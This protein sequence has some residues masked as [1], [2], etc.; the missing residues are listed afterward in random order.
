MK[1]AIVHIADI[2]YRK[3]EPEGVSRVLD[4]FMQDLETQK[5]F[6]S[7][8]SFYIAFTGDMVFAGQ[9][10]D[11][12]QTLKNELNLK[13]DKI[14][15]SYES[16]I[17]VPGNH[18]VE[19]NIVQSNLQ[20]TQEQLSK[21]LMNEQ[22]FNSFVFSENDLAEKFTNYQIFE[23]EFARYGIDFSI[24]GKGWELNDS[25]GIYCLNSALTSF[26]GVNDI[27]D[28]KKLAICTRDLTNWCAR[29]KTSTN[30]LLMH[31]PID[32]LIDWSKE[33]I[34]LLIE[35]N[36]ILCL[37][38]HNHEQNIFYNQISQKALI[39][40]APQLF[41]CKGDKLGYAIILLEND[42]PD[43]ILYRQYVKGNFLNGSYFSQNNEGIVVIPTSYEKVKPVKNQEILEQR[44]KNS[45]VS[46]KNQPDLFIEPKLSKS[47]E[48]NN[49][50]NQLALVIQNPKAAFIIAQPQFGLTCLAHYMRLEAYKK[51]KFWIYV[52]AEHV[53][54][55]NV[56]K[57]IEEQLK[58]F[59]KNFNEIQC[60]LIDSW[61]DSNQDNQKLLKFVDSEYSEIPIIVMSSYLGINYSSNLDF[62]SLKT[63]FEFLHLQAL[64]RDKV[65]K[66]V[67]E[68]NK[69]KRIASD[70]E[71]I[72]KVVK[73]LEALN[74]HRTPLNCYTL[75]RVFERD[76]NES[77]LNRT[78]MIKIVLF[79]LFTDV[80]SIS[81]GSTKPD[82]DDVE[83][84][85]GKFCKNL[86]KQRTTRFD[87]TEFKTELKRFS[88][89]ALFSINVEQIIDILE[90]NYI[91]KRFGDDF[92]FRHSYWI[93]YFAAICMT[94]DDEFRDYIL[95]SRNYVNFPEIIEFY[96]GTNG[97]RES[98]VVTLIKDTNDLVKAVSN[99]IG[100]REEFN[101]F[102]DVLWNPTKEDI[103]LIRREISEI[104]QTSNLPTD[105]KDQ[106]ADEAYDSEAPYNQSINKFLNEYMVVSLIQNIK[107]SSRALRNSNYVKP[108]FKKELFQSILN[109]WEQI[110]RVIFWLAPALA[111]SGKVSYDGYGLLLSEKFKGTYEEVLRDIFLANPTNV[112]NQ[113]KDDLSSK[114]IG[115]IL[116]ES[117]QNNPS[118]IQKHFIARFLIKERPIGWHRIIFNHMN[119]LHPNSFYL[120]DLYNTVVNE[121][122]NEF[123]S[124][125]ELGYLKK[126][127]SVV[128]A[129]V[130]YSP[131][132]K[133]NFIENNL[134]IS[135]KNKLPIDKIYA[136]SKSH[137]YRK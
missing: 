60:I 30:I 36:F 14:G 37:S 6:L 133:K 38:G 120:G 53:K 74:I 52:D 103:D 84:V 130:Q 59:D 81:Y 11:T 135:D 85:L 51:N 42:L 57:E 126:L 134:R 125:E 8:Y 90:S 68:Y 129:K 78:K 119:T 55:R 87:A 127:I 83:Y 70:D 19:Q 27:V 2:H 58:I 5:K 121:L 107:A 128:D 118:T 56:V 29:K 4:A 94:I 104:V 136:S 92:E 116:F 7:D 113:F 3:N 110:S 61:D 100:V 65:R 23:S 26:G 137:K 79:I 15:F 46:F 88:V 47:R 105:L 112:V 123:I 115:P 80:T 82:V 69:V 86:I 62:S 97:Q 131:K 71:L 99:K 76:F 12:Y 48:F 54:S 72:T 111:A 33:E 132:K 28:E 35:G 91:L 75:L 10:E 106:H 41:T 114:K 9:E 117:L 96:T 122:K 98:A 108:G 101:P 24:G 89:E 40:S 22:I 34:K 50:D 13:L 31:H 44:L 93:Y 95:N 49:D 43:R 25:L 1:N 16:R 17:M 21:I 102:N 64:Q 32:H 66:F 77:I 124:D 45:L 63:S 18:D 67:S 20:K 39:C 109:G 73:E